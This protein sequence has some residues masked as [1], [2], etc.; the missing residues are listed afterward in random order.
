[1]LCVE[2]SS[3]PMSLLK[4]LSIVCFGPVIFD[5]TIINKYVLDKGMIVMCSEAVD[6][7]L[8][9][10]REEGKEGGRGGEGEGGREGVSE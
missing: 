5:A 9:R 4:T 6:R 8:D 1:M 2:H 7:N 10:G 3:H